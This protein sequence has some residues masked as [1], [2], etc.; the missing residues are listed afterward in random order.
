MVKDCVHETI[1]PLFTPIFDV[2]DTLCVESVVIRGGQANGI[3]QGVVD[4]AGTLL[5]HTHCVRPSFAAVAPE[6]DVPL[7]LPD[8]K[9]PDLPD[10]AC[11]LEY[12][13]DGSLATDT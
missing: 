10:S 5:D 11:S 13:P 12:H 6:M 3:A 9:H 2:V 4:L 1:G 8:C 7:C